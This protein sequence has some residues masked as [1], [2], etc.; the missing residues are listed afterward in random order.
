[1]TQAAQA[2]EAMSVLVVDDDED[3]R[4]AM[5]GALLELGY[6]CR[7][8]QDGVDAWEMH[9]AARAD[10]ILSDW[11]MPRMDG[12]ELCKRVRDDD[13][14]HPYTHFIFV[15]GNSDKAH[16]I[17]GMHAGADD[18]MAK[19]VDIDELRARLEVARRVVTLR[20]QLSEQNAHLRRDSERAHV[21]ARVDPLTD[22]F[23]R[24]A[25]KEDL[26]ALAARA[27]RYGHRYCAALCDIDDFKAYND[28]FGHL[29]GDE[30]LRRVAH[31]IRD[32]VRR[33]DVCY[34]YGGEEF[35]VIL[36]EQYLAEAALG[37]DRVRLRVE[38]LA[39]PHAPGAPWPLVTMSVG[40]GAL[41]TG[42][43]PSIDDWLQRADA[44][45]YAAKAQGKNRI[46]LDGRA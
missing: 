31:T 18:Y 21:A 11:T 17:H 23:N 7:G 8:A 15:T 45:L 42:G 27:V 9:A 6:A 34:R 13:S 22:A 2:A 12:L 14:R 4:E 40:I 39:V 1:M 16:F 46:V 37:M 3:Y 33:G 19:P 32:A 28:H 26:E 30:V 36:P 25:L 5:E 43:A 38:G 10:V 41:G 44:A 29:A 20:R 24:L 35:L